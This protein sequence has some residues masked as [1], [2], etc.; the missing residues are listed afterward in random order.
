MKKLRSAKCSDRF[1][2]TGS[3][4]SMG[5]RYETTTRAS[6]NLSISARHHPS[7]FFLAGTLFFNRIQRFAE[8][9]PAGKIGTR[10]ITVSQ[11]PNLTDLSV[12]LCGAILPCKM[13][14][15]FT[16]TT[17]FRGR[18]GCLET[19]CTDAIPYWVPCRARPYVFADSPVTP[20]PGSRDFL[21]DIYMWPIS[22]NGSAPHWEQT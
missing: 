16:A 2:T 18:A 17:A 11:L 19:S 1:S 22:E 7:G 21:H 14:V 8:R 4:P 5:E 10:L 9:F 20:R 15:D 12:S 13:I 3:I 6:R